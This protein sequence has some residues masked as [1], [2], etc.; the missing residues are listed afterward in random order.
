M[1]ANYYHP[2]AKKAIRDLLK[3]LVYKELP[4]YEKSIIDLLRDSYHVYYTARDI[5]AKEGI[6]IKKSDFHPTLFDAAT[7]KP[8]YMEHSALKVFNNAQ[9]QIHKYLKILFP[10]SYAKQVEEPE[11]ETQQ[12][13]VDKFITI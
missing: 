9:F 1:T 4:R 13:P 5:L 12:T 11:E 6:L 8:E 10:R 7:V 3:E 2:D